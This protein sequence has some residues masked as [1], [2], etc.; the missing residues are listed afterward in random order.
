MYCGGKTSNDY[1]GNCGACGAPRIDSS[2]NTFEPP[3]PR[4]SISKEKRLTILDACVCKICHNFM[5]VKDGLC[6][7]CGK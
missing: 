2:D 1:L 4:Y 3:I 6:H 5:A 7:D